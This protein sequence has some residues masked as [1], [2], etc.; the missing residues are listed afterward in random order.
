MA[1]LG[2][3]G[4]VNTDE[5]APSRSFTR[6]AVLKAGGLAGLALALPARAL[7]LTRAGSYLR[8][9][10][11]GGLVGEPFSIQGSATKLSLIAVQD[12][13]A[14][15]AGSDNAFALVFRAPNGA[16]PIANPVPQLYHR[17]F[18]SFQLLLS[19]GM[20]SNLGQPYIAVINRLH[21]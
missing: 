6:R 12:L 14:G 17:A 1:D 4:E 19:P 11:Y 16:A 8:R 5:A 13:N 10:S 18:G 7:G 21:A 9:S 20:P 15:Q 3:R 2:A